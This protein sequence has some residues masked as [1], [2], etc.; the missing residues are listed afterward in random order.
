M[1]PLGND[2]PE[3][4]IELISSNYF[5]GVLCMSSH[6]NLETLIF[7]FANFWS[8]IM[9]IVLSVCML[10]GLSVFAEALE[11]TALFLISESSLCLTV[12]VTGILFICRTTGWQLCGRSVSSGI[13]RHP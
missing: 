7:G 10:V 6:K 3:T 12:L 8:Y 2:A 1:N 5:L 11:D 4:I 9:L 13:A